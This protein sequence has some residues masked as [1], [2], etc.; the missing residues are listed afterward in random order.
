MYSI[1]GMSYCARFYFMD[2]NKFSL[3]VLLKLTF[4]ST[5]TCILLLSYLLIQME[6]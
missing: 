3:P 5:H 6:N 1:D 2:I 4:Y